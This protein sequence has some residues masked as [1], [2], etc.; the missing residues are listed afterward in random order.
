MLSDGS[1]LEDEIAVADAH[2]L[3]AH[4]FDRPQYIEKFRTLAE[5]AVAPFEQERFLAACESLV[6][7]GP[8]DLGSL[9]VEADTDLLATA[10][11]GLL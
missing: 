10:G 9:G 7:L 11:G 4:P 3:G 2:P 8:A 1:V 6:E 5:R